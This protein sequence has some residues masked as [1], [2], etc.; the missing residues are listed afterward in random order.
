[1]HLPEQLTLS[2]IEFNIIVTFVFVLQSLAGEIHMTYSILYGCYPSG[3]V[4]HYVWVDQVKYTPAFYH[5]AWI[6]VSC[7]EISTLF[8]HKRRVL[9]LLVSLLPVLPSFTASEYQFSNL[10][11]FLNNTYHGLLQ[12]HRFL[13]HISFTTLPL[14]LIV[15]V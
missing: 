4:I 5:G 11:T 7:W 10:Q 2:I 14:F 15:R 8:V 1:M 6:S 13:P 3:R 9:F 12:C